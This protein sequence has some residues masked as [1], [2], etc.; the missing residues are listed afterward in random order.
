MPIAA[1][2]TGRMRPSAFW[3]VPKL[4]AGGWRTAARQIPQHP[5]MRRG[6]AGAELLHVRGAVT[7]DNIRQRTHYRS[8]MRWPT[9]SAAALEACSVM[10]V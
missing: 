7:A 2:V 5:L 3:A 6:H 9:W 4:A 8:L 1:G 10:W